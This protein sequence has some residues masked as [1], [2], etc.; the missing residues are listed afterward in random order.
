MKFK[1]GDRIKCVN[2]F[3]VIGVRLDLDKVYT[4]S[5]V[6]KLTSKPYYAIFLKECINKDAWFYSS[7]FEII[8]REELLEG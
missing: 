3:G 2:N 7:R 4:I 5:R 1:P 6:S 8:K